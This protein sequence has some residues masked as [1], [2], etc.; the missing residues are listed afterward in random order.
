MVVDPWRTMGLASIEDN[1]PHRL[2]NPAV[3]PYVAVAVLSHLPSVL[4]LFLTPASHSNFIIIRCNTPSTNTSFF[5]LTHANMV[6]VSDMRVL[7]TPDSNHT[8]FKTVG[9]Y[10]PISQ[11]PFYSGLGLFQ[12]AL[13][14]WLPCFANGTVGA[15]VGVD[16]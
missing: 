12:L 1:A 2:P 14:E 11:E 10:S 8:D 3:P 5:G 7:L 6:H 13:D 15:S 9:F 4:S 16:V